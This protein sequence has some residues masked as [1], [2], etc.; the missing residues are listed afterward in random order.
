[1]TQWVSAAASQHQGPGCDSQLGSLSVRSLHVLPVSAWVSSGAPV[2]SHSPKGVLVRWI[3]HAK[4]SLSV[5]GQVPECDDS[6]I[7][8]VTSLQC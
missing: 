3:G 6:G 2:S 4:L 8:T 5:P 1:M 7:F